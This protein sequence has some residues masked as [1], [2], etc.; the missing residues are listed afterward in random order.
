VSTGGGFVTAYQSLP[1][2]AVTQAVI[3][4]A[5]KCVTVDHVATVGVPLKPL[6]LIRFAAA[7]K[8]VAAVDDTTLDGFTTSFAPATTG[9]IHAS[10]TTRPAARRARRA[11]HPME[12]KEIDIVL[13]QHAR[14]MPVSA[15]F[16]P[17][18]LGRGAGEKSETSRV[19]ETERGTQANG[20][21]PVN[22]EK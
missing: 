14:Q 5:P 6:P 22:V 2:A 1:L 4:L 8:S 13:P 3:A 7:Y 21:G 20:L 11:R 10:A 17:A 9:T 19:V 15:K 12:Q 16:S 18:P